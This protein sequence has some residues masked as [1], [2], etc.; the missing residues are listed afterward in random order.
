MSENTP[1]DTYFNVEEEAT[2]TVKDIIKK[3]K[4]KL[5]NPP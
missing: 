5:S 1:Y 2:S 4:T 3:V